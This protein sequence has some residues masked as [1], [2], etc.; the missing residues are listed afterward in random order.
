MNVPHNVSVE[1]FLRNFQGFCAF[2]LPIDISY[3]THFIHLFYSAT[4]DQKASF[5][6]FA[7]EVQ[8]LKG[9][10]PGALTQMFS[11]PIAET[12]RSI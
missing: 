6:E 11:A 4:K 1:Q 10:Y 2:L 12:I 3:F 9:Y 8:N 7:Q 5:V